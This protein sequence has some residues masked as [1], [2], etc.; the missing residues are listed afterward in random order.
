[1]NLRQELQEHAFRYYSYGTSTISDAEYDAKFDELIQ[2]EKEHPDMADANSPTARVGSPIPNGLIKVKH[3]VRMLSLEKVK[4]A[5]DAQSFFSGLDGGDVLV[6]M[7]IDGLSL[8]LSYVQGNL[9]QAIT[10]GDGEEGEDVTLNARTV[11][12][13]PLTLRDPVTI[14]VRG[15]VY[16][17]LSSFNA[18]NQTVS[19]EN[20]F[21]NSRNGAT[22]SMALKDSRLVAKRRLDF[23][24]YSISSDVPEGVDTQEALL[25]YLETLGFTTPMTLPVTADTCGLPYVICPAKSE[26]LQVAISYMKTYQASLDLVTDGL[27]IKA[28]ELALQRDLGEGTRSPRWAVAF[29]F[30]PEVKETGLVGITLQVGKTGQITPVAELEP[31]QLGGTTV[32]RASL[33]N[34]DELNRL[35]VSVGD[36]VLVQRSGEVIPKVIGLAK[37][38]SQSS[39]YQ[40]P[41]NCPC[42]GTAL[43][44]PSG[45]V[46]LYCPNTSEC[47]DQVF[48][49][50]LFA[51]SKDALDIDGC[52]DVMVRRLMKQGVRSLSDLFAL[53]DL[54]FLKSGERRNL[55]AGRE[56]AKIAPLWRKLAALSIEGIG[57]ERC[58]S[59]ATEFHAVLGLLKVKD[60]T[61]DTGRE[62]SS[63]LETCSEDDLDMIEQRV[64]AVVGDVGKC[65]IV[66][67]VA[68]NITELDRLAALGFHLRPETRTVGPLSGKSFCITG[69]LVSGGR[70]D[71]S[72]LIVKHG[73]TVKGTVTKLVDF[74]VRGESGGNNKAKAAEKHGTAIITEDQL[75]QM[76]GIPMTL[77]S[78][79][80][81]P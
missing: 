21:A 18:Y 14:D 12:T 76:M 37:P 71:V 17:R 66:D 68:N 32:Q 73:G 6:E 40:I 4:Q 75:Y 8:H 72:A 3:K 80:L 49:R 69:S 39:P 77:K 33:C 26:E 61:L 38:S 23:V 1:M 22:G 44:K 25:D 56:A 9:V 36:R 54:S 45:M 64:K 78:I 28:S 16:W 51:F 35:G 20:Q 19:R 31:V 53:E 43:V 5:D 42:C 11:R 24:A 74:L 29:K 30:P 46:H 63:F 50:L 15:E 47:E 13:I 48:A 57:K 7:K 10:R 67:Y 2:L 52:G 70:D 81:N 59:L 55:E 34:Q 79:N 27:V 58:Q 62:V 65:S 60:F 41:H